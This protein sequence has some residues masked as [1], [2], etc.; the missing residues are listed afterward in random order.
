MQRETDSDCCETARLR[1]ASVDLM[2]ASP[3]G[4]NKL[5]L[6]QDVAVHRR[7]KL[8]PGRA[9]RQIEPKVERVEP[10]EVAVCAMRRARAAVFRMAETGGSLLRARGK[11]A[12]RRCAFGQLTHTGRDVVDDPVNEIDGRVGI[13]HRE[14]EAFCAAWRVLPFELR[15]EVGAVAGIAARDGTVVGEIG[16][17][18][19]DRGARLTVHGCGALPKQKRR[20]DTDGE[21]TDENMNV[22]RAKWL[23][24]C[25][26]FFPL[27]SPSRSSHCP[28]FDGADA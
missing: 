4:A 9:G 25:G 5:S 18:E 23:F 16:T 24:A 8:L 12:T 15:R 11:R 1:A 21:D 28:T 26:I 6:R 2:S 22:L 17:G 19:C 20:H 7:F 27:E 10:E 13:V 14:G 3:I